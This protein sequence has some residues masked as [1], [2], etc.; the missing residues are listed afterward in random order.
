MTVREYIGNY[1]GGNRVRFREVWAEVKEW[2]AEVRAGNRAGQREE[3]GD[4]FHF[5]QLW[6]YWRFGLNQKLWKVATS[7]TDKF[8]ARLKIWQKIYEYAG[9]DKNI[10]RFCGNC[11]KEEKVVRQL[12]R[13]G[14]SE[15]KARET[16]R[17][18]VGLKEQ[19]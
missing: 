19:T 11:H 15:E 6:F 1:T 2:W 16:Y 9:L 7:S 3:W 13:F 10:S 5:L 14:I 8:M 17:M 4:I 18:V 12:G